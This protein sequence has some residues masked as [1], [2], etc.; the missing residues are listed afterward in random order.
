MAVLA[1]RVLFLL[2]TDP[3][4]THIWLDF[5]SFRTSFLLGWGALGLQ[6]GSQVATLQ[7]VNQSD[8]QSQ[9]SHS[10]VAIQTRIDPAIA[11]L[12]QTDRLSTSLTVLVLC[13]ELFPNTDM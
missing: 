12:R 6:P 1:V 7:N 13:W 10:S 9:S 2:R 4:P 5:C 8:P 11:K 3:G